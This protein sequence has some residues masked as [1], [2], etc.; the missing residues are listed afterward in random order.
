MF[1][2]SAAAHSGNAKLGMQGDLL[3]HHLR[4]ASVQSACKRRSLESGVRDVG[5]LR[6][7]E[8]VLH[9]CHARS[10][11]LAYRAARSRV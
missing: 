9:N 3:Y 6:S 2:G 1:Y 7:V 5:P 8:H 4:H 10:H 11:S